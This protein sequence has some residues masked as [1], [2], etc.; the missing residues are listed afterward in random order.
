M[1]SELTI[2][3]S[4]AGWLIRLATAYRQRDPVLLIDDA[5][6]GIDPTRQTL[7][8]MGRT[9]VLNRREWAGVLV[10]LGLTGIGLWMVVAAVLDPEPTSK[11]GLLIGGG[12]ACL[13]GGGFSA[14]RILT[15]SRPPTV[16]VGVRGIQI[17]WD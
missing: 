7:L 6:V 12:T 1:P 5:Q 8:D 13:L 4:E 14:V 3:T 15:R 9:A 17:H 2:R 10:S 16:E 11:L